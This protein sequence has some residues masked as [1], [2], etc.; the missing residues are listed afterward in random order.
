MVQIFRFSF[1]FW[2]ALSFWGCASTGSPSGGPKDNQPPRLV[3]EKSTA[4]F[5]TGF[6]PS[7]IKL[8]FDEWIVLKKGGQDV[9]ISP[10]FFKS[11][12]I[13][14]RGKSVKVKFP[15]DES[16]KENATYIIDFGQ[17]IVDFTEGNPVKDLKFVFSTGDK[18]D[19]I[20]MKGKIMPAE[21]TVKMENVLV[22]LY[23]QLEDSIIVR[24][25]PLYYVR[26]DNK[27]NFKFDY[28]RADT[29]LLVAVKDLN[30][31]YFWDPES[32][33]IAFYS[34]PIVISDTMMLQ[35][36]LKIFSMDNGVAIADFSTKIPGL[37]SIV[38]DRSIDT[39]AYQIVCPDDKIFYEDLSGDTL[40]I[41]YTRQL[42]SLCM[43][44]GEDKKDTMIFSLP[45]IDSSFYK[46][47][48][49]LAGNN[50]VT[51]LIDSV[52]G[53]ELTFG[54]PIKNFDEQ[55]FILTIHPPK[56]N[57]RNDKTLRASIDSLS[58]QNPKDSLIS[59]PVKIDSIQSDSLM[60]IEA[61]A[62]TIK[63]ANFDIRQKNISTLQMSSGW[64]PGMEYELMILP[65]GMTDIYG[66]ENDSMKVTFTVANPDI[67]VD[68]ELVLVGLDSTKNYIVEMYRDKNPIESAM[69]KG[70]DTVNVLFLHKMIGK[71]KVVITQ[72]DNGDGQWTTGDYW[73]KRQPEIKKSFDL[74]K[75]EPGFKL[76][77]TLTWN[78]NILKDGNPAKLKGMRQDTMGLDSLQ[79]KKLIDKNK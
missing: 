60:Q 62:D 33:D 64:K 24:E 41:F 14:S 22:M 54:S 12:K 78:D 70:K 69:V 44:Y 46:K 20:S 6:F 51:G 35:P 26:A 16:L 63:Y 65:G 57:K 5:Q 48:I 19:S 76:S 42:D 53:L 56:K 29:F 59:S 47:N 52:Q 21:S 45:R 27:G 66:R 39:D 34:E 15:K 67:F 55:R 17:S 75:A 18:I 23:D 73:Q 38:F 37:V 25:R 31:N 40:K 1:L 30:Y 32:E 10:P 8:T 50:M 7:E 71:Y 2:T 36:Q 77:T 49:R 28:L 72:D 79:N 61:L 11:P 9:L 3:A 74:K 58:S 4:N 68:M 43:A 13:T